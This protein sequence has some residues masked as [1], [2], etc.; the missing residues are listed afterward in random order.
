MLSCLH[1]VDASLTESLVLV[2]ILPGLLIAEGLSLLCLPHT[3]PYPELHVP[4]GPWAS[5]GHGMA[6]PHTT[7]FIG[8]FLGK[9]GA[10]LTRAQHPKLH[11]NSVSICCISNC[12]RGCNTID[13]NLVC[14]RYLML[15]LSP[16]TTH[17]VPR[18]EP[19]DSNPSQNPQ[20][21][22]SHQLDSSLF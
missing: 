9:V 3:K 5:L 16:Q 17:Q 10:I 11:R 21:F 15:H 20:P 4:K 2:T 19:K 7:V 22:L 18:N 6:Y 8:L 12:M 14:V 13:G 1:N